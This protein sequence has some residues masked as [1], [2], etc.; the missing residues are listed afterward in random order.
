MKGVCEKPTAH[1]VPNGE[2]LTV[3][4]PKSRT[5][6][7]M[8]A[9]TLLFSIVLKVLARVISQENYIQCIQIGKKIDILK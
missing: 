8:S 9:L 6:T 7:R 4:S 1:I 5:T 2:R 3:F